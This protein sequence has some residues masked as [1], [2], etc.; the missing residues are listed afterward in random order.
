MPTE[1]I[2]DVGGGANHYPSLTTWEAGEQGNLVAL[3]QIHT[4]RCFAYED[5]GV[6]IDGSTT[7][8]TRYLQITVDPSARHAGVW[9]ST[10]FRIRITGATASCVGA[11]DEHVRVSGLQ[12]DVACSNNY[13]AQG[14]W[15]YLAGGSRADEEIQIDGC[16][17]RGT[18]YSGSGEP[19]SN[20]FGVHAQ[21]GGAGCTV[22]VSNC[23]AYDM[24]GPGTTGG[25]GFFNYAVTAGRIYNCTAYNCNIGFRNGWNP[26]IAK[27]C[28][29]QACT[30][31]F[32]SSAAWAAGT[33]NNASDIAS[34]AP[35]TTTYTG[36]A[37]FVNAAAKNFHLAADDFS[38]DYGVNLS[39]DAFYPITTDIDDQTRSGTWDIGAD[40]YIAAGGAFLA[41]VPAGS[42][43]LTGQMPTI[44][45]VSVIWPTILRLFTINREDRQLELVPES[46]IYHVLPEQRRFWI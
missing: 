39:A 21:S 17:M 20:A 43:R 35:G 36:T 29:A 16:L 2:K 6:T 19:G 44:C 5:S 46:R 24:R 22:K 23:I 1:I 7:D 32:F 9:D 4:A 31:G 40:E 25:R 18:Y 14:V 42:I 38:I 8:P 10:K 27:N 3:D 12:L 33:T 28:L 26:C 45:I 11:L 41:I 37:T 34:D 15:V 13:G 30:D